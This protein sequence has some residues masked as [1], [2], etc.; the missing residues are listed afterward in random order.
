MLNTP[1]HYDTIVIGAGP[2]GTMAA[3]LLSK[4]GNSVLI[5]SPQTPSV[6]YYNFIP[7]AISDELSLASESVLAAE[8]GKVRIMLAGVHFGDASFPTPVSLVD[9]R[10]FDAAMLDAAC[11]AGAEV[12]NATAKRVERDAKGWNVLGEDFSHTGDRLLFC[13]G[14]AKLVDGVVFKGA[15]D[16]LRVVQCTGEP[17]G[18]SMDFDIG[19][20]GSAFCWRVGDAAGGT[21]DNEVSAIRHKAYLTARCE[22]EPLVARLDVFSRAGAEYVH[23]RAYR[24][25]GSA[26]LVDP[27]TGEGIRYA[28]Q[29]ARLCAQNIV[30][31][32]P[33]REYGEALRDTVVSELAIARRIARRIASVPDTVLKLSAAFPKG[34][35]LLRGLIAVMSGEDTYSE[36]YRRYKGE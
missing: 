36:V 16:R 12:L 25:G 4:A 2:A 30:N 3:K 27:L 24:L 13:S 5:I 11:A 19:A 9:R 15:C 1:K 35:K 29:S 26:A 14:A 7:P 18:S 21:F 20:R 22:I 17:G 33:E 6:R 23:D 31:G 28:L 32:D 8:V 34:R 10:R